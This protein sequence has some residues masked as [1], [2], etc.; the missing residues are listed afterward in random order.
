MHFSSKSNPYFINQTKN[1]RKTAGT[2]R[3]R[4]GLNVFMR[5]LGQK[6]NREEEKEDIFT[7]HFR[8]LTKR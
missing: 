7:H 8:C 6:K 5:S 3:K 4:S 2:R 1:F